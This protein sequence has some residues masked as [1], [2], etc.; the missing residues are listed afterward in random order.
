M[1]IERELSTRNSCLSS[2]FRANK[3]ISWETL[4]SQLYTQFRLPRGFN[5]DVQGSTL[6][7]WHGITHGDKMEHKIE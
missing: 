6:R 5:D 2:D 4:A 1:E 7:L 3:L